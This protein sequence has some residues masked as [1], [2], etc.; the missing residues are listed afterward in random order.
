MT[1]LPLAARPL[2]LSVALAAFGVGP[3]VHW[4]VL[5]YARSTAAR[6][7]AEARGSGP[8]AV[9]TVLSVRPTGRWL[10]GSPVLAVRMRVEAGAGSPA[11]EARCSV[12]PSFALREG[13]SYRIRVCRRDRFTVLEDR[14]IPQTSPKGRR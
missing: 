11:R 12:A 8:T 7:E 5:R 13:R 9:G 4:A 2:L 3:L 10:D 1:A 14:Q 6:R